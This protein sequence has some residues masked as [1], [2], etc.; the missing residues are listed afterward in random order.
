MKHPKQRGATGH[1]GAPLV[2]LSFNPQRCDESLEIGWIEA[3]PAEGTAQLEKMATSMNQSAVYWKGYTSTSRQP[4]LMEHLKAMKE[5]LDTVDFVSTQLRTWIG[6]YVQNIKTI[7]TVG[8]NDDVRDW[9][10]EQKHVAVAIQGKQQIYRGETFYKSH[11]RLKE[12]KSVGT[13]GGG[14]L[15]EERKRITH[16]WKLMG[17]SLVFYFFTGLSHL[18]REPWVQVMVYRS[19]SDAYPGSNLR[20]NYTSYILV[21]WLSTVGIL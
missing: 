19:S 13:N 5:M 12:T 15:Y 6:Q 10:N 2:K 21:V 9:F 17:I 20:F 7:V 18:G 11:I 4:L 8:T 14:T 3:K 1:M 16:G